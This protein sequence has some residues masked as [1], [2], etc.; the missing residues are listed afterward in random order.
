MTERD[1]PAGAF[2]DRNRHAGDVRLMRVQ[3]GLVIVSVCVG[4]R[5][6]K[7]EGHHARVADVV[8]NVRNAADRLI[9]IH[10]LYL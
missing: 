3:R 8:F 1:V 9:I 6:L 2:F 10:S 5:C 4:G 7:V